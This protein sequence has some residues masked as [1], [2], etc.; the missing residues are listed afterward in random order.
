MK[1]FAHFIFLYHLP[2]SD[3]S[4]FF[5]EFANYLAHIVTVS[6]YLLIVGHFNLHVDSQNHAGR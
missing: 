1:C 2:S 5:D 3:V 6:G 4:L